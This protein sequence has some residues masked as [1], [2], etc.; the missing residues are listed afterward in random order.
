VASKPLVIGLSGPARSGKDTAA[1]MLLSLLPDA[2][3]DS[4][5]APIRETACRIF[6]MTLAELEQRKE[7]PVGWLGVSPRQ[8][9]QKMGTE[10]GREMISD[11]LWVQ[12]LLERNRNAP[13]LIVSDV[14][15]ENEASAI[16]ARGGVIIH[17]RRPQAA[18]VA[19]HVSERGIATERGDFIVHNSLS[20][21]FLR[22]ELQWIVDQLRPELALQQPL[23]LRD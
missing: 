10:F 3:Q 12:S 19:A 18:A 6:G 9:M 1:G 15:F 21:D 17:L 4:F 20:L 22:S 16:R 14:R 23:L 11:S 2:V 8:F 7:E 13:V 5:A